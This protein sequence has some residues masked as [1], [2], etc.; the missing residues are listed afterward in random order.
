ML[1]VCYWAMHLAEPSLG[2]VTYSAWQFTG[3][4]FQETKLRNTIKTGF[5]TSRIRY[6]VHGPSIHSMNKAA[7]LFTIAQ[8][9]HPTWLSPQDSSRYIRPFWRYHIRSDCIELTLSLTFLD[10][11]L[12]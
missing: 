7:I 4:R 1:D 9:P 6:R 10:S 12:S 3:V 8:G 11:Y 2:P 5:S